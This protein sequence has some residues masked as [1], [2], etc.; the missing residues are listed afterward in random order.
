[1]RLT[2]RAQGF[3]GGEWSGSV[4]LKLRRVDGYVLVKEVKKRRRDSSKGSSTP[5]EGKTLT[6]V[7]RDKA[8]LMDLDVSLGAARRTPKPERLEAASRAREG[9]GGH[10]ELKARIEGDGAPRQESVWGGSPVGG[11]AVWDKQ[12][13]VGGAVAVSS[14]AST[15][16]GR[17]TVRPSHTAVK[18]EGGLGCTHLPDASLFLCPQGRSGPKPPV[19]VFSVIKYR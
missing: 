18:A 1:V 15:C 2:R 4:P 3:W 11:V 19:G 13:Q 7:G 16:V 8:R 12:R 17:E 6:D 9:E 10:G 14:L 5:E